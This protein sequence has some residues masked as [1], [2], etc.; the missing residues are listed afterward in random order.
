MLRNDPHADGRGGADP[1]REPRLPALAWLPR[2]RRLRTKITCYYLALFILVLS[3]IVA[4]VYVSV[5]RNVKR[6]VS[7]ELAAS[8]VVFDRVWQLR[9]A[10]L[11]SGAEL[12][13]RDFG[14]RAAVA[15]RDQATIQSALA[16]LRRRMGLQ[17]AFVLDQD[18]RVLASD[19]VALPPTA[20]AALQAHGDIGS[21]SGVVVLPDGPY[22]AVSAPILAPTFIGDVVFAMRLDRQEMAS[23]V[24]LSP[25]DFQ[26][27]VLVRDAEGR[28][29][30]GAAAISR[31][32]LAHAAQALA[33]GVPERPEAAKIGPWLEVVRPLQTLGPESAV[34]LLRYPMSKAL[35][36]FQGLL[37][38]IL[39]V[40]GA[41]ALMVAAG[42]W[43]L[44]REVTRPIGAL[45]QAAEQ[46]E[47]GQASRVTVEGRDEI[48]TLG[49]TFNR[50]AE[51]ILRREQ[52][53]ES[54]REIAEAANRAKSDFLANMSHEIRTPLNG[55]LGMAQVMGREDVEGT[56]RPRLKVIRDSGEA[57]LGVLNSILDL[58]KIE[59]GQLEIEVA[60]F[61]LSE[62]IASA[63]DP[64]ATLAAQKGV[65]LAMEIDPAAAGAWRG[66]PLR[67][68]Q[69]LSNLASNAVKFTEAGQIVLRVRRL[70]E[71][72]SFEMSDTGVG[73]PR[74]RL[75]AIFDKFAQADASS[76]RRFGGAG[77][78][79]AICRE[80]VAL[81]GGRIQVESEPGR[82]SRFAFELPLVRVSA[83]PA[84]DAEDAEASSVEARRLRI[85]AAED[86]PT[87]QV[88]L[89]AL[90]EPAGVALTMVG[91]GREALEAM[92]GEAF[93]LVLM[94]IQMPDMNGVEATLAIRRSEAARGAPPTPILAL[95][96][97][98]MR[99]QI[100]EYLAAGMDGVVAKPIQAE[101]LF[102][103]I[104]QV[105]N[106]PSDHAVPRATGVG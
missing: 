47:R 28:W 56:H 1:A 105:L 66:D 84:G 11:E 5:E 74:E 73:I 78:G 65:A 35:A 15:T 79:L 82:G 92:A 2:F 20:I 30:T 95:S 103:E 51:G 22:H 87:N 96:A 42:G 40:G 60:E 43:L 86:N 91:D 100:D 26:P 54:A 38:L 83:L 70:P 53:L 8:A 39:L 12:L 34:L 61:K 48:A 62:L 94:D 49:L 106:E 71:G 7:H 23:L 52:A 19:G 29:R 3:G 4:A 41:G 57:L 64:F 24:R 93:D 6:V 25:T 50:M 21:R 16:N 32:E 99:H 68:R 36:P 46:L 85:L 18:G 14:F 101:V 13:S 17:L 44:A 37:A 58:S 104:E 102:M 90:L 55:I 31:A 98:V 77:L 45:D 9:T 72:L 10:G 76:T 88:I 63:C 81:M 75:D 97:N 59:A 27:Q 67:L 69:V 33:Q 89:A 80:L